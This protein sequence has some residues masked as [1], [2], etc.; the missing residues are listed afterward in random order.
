MSL[1]LPTAVI[2]TF[3]S[4]HVLKPC[5]DA[6]NEQGVSII[7]VDNASTDGS[8]EYAA[9][10]GATVIHNT[11]NQGYGRAN[12]QGIRAAQSD[13][14]LIVNP[15]L[16]VEK[17]AIAALLKATIDYPQAG[18]LA[19]QIVE[20]SGRIFFQPRSMLSRTLTN[21]H[22]KLSIPQYD[23]CTPFVSGA[24]MCVNRAVFLALD[25]FDANIFLFYEDDDLCRRMMDAGHEVVFIPQ[26]RAVHLR[27]Q[28][29]QPVRGHVYK[30]RWHQA[31]SR[32][33]VARKYGLKPTH[34]RDI[35]KNAPKYIGSA[36]VFYRSGMERYGGTCAGAWA[37][38]K[39]KSAT[40]SIDIR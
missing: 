5:M 13:Y 37:S 27:G 29:S 10:L 40:S 34:I 19:P 39:K 25:G 33:Y 20:P 32:G 4:A 26:A 3:N 24:C 9:Q 35:L 1:A 38:F 36:L 6:L 18:I 31:W 28:S 11:Q 21:P 30:S 12:N 15:D 23:A 7:I 22:G 16:V 17:G 8:A 2:V 14:V